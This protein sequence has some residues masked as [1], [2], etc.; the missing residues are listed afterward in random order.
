MLKK[1]K[2]KL[3]KADNRG[4]S[5]VLVIV[6]ATFL[7]ILVSALL[8]GVLLAYKLRFYKLNSLNNF[9]SVEKAMDEIYAG[10]GASTNEHL[11]SAY[12]TTAEI[13]VY[14][15]GG[16][17]ANLTETEANDLFKK[18]FMQSIMEDE[19]FTKMP[20]LVETLQT[21]ITDSNVELVCDNLKIVYTD[22][23]GQEKYVKYEQLPNGKVTSTTSTS[24]GSF[25][26]NNIESITFKNLSVQRTINL[27]PESSGNAYAASGTYVQSI[28][29]DLT[30]RKPE[31]N[32]SFDI[33]GA[34]SD[35]LYNYALLADMGLQVTGTSADTD[36]NIKG[37]VYTASDYYNK[38]YNDDSS[39]KVTNEYNRTVETKWGSTDESAYSGIFVQGER[40]NLSMSSDVVVNSGS[41]A[42]FD[43]AD[44]ILA[45]RTTISSELWTDNIIIGGSEG[46]TI[47][48][49]ANAYVYDD[50][51]L[52]AEKSNLTFTMGSYFGYSYTADDVRSINLLRTAGNLATG[53]KLK[54]HFS[55]S[56][57]IVNGKDS[58]LDFRKLD[59]LY[60]AG[61]SYIEFSKVAASTIT[62]ETERQNM[63]LTDDSD[64]AFTTLNDYSTGQSLD[65]KS[66]QLIF[67]TQWELY[68]DAE[69]TDENGYTHVTLKFPK[70]FSNDVTINNLYQDFIDVLTSNI[71]TV[72]AI[73][74]TVSG[75]D[76]YYLYIEEG[77]N[78]NDGVDDAEEFVEKYYDLLN[79]GVDETVKKLYN[80]VDYDDFQVKL[81]LPTNDSG[82][83]DDTKINASGAV[84]AQ[85][86]DNTL[87]VKASADT[88]LNVENA[89]KSAS[90]SKTFSML[91]G[92]KGTAENNQTFEDL[93]T[94][95]EE[96]AISNT[97]SQEEKVSNF[98]NYMY[99][100]LKDH[101]SVVDK[102]DA[103]DNDIS[104]YELAKYTNSANG[105]TYNA[106]K[107]SNG[108]KLDT[109]DYDYS[110]T[111]L[112]YYVDYDKIF[113]EN[114]AINETE[115]VTN[116]IVI[117]NEND[118]TL[119]STAT[120][121][122]LQGII[123][124][125]GNVTIDSSVKSFRGMIITGAKIIC[126][127][128]V[129]ID[130]S[131]DAS[132][133]ARV[134]EECAKSSNTKLSI[135]TREILK[136]Y[137]KVDESGETEV[138]SSSLS[139]ISYSDILMFQNWKK[140]VE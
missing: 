93:K 94:K 59:A 101:L 87:F 114:L 31:Y 9:Y 111:P 65:V 25:D 135:L 44:I 63:G 30:L 49:A 103:D 41:L 78:D 118:V 64:Y 126:G 99:I 130:I 102:Q 15:K 83:V 73:K 113:T 57:V 7:S 105:Y 23:N 110:L 96:L 34:N 53:F 92:N 61:K 4:S 75:H 54:S 69:T 5:F 2:K 137:E 13:V 37:N 131:A 104:A 119:R 108:D 81:I 33:A 115:P 42:A 14:Y 84:T 27:T 97:A 21:Y 67:L 109:F 22:K 70:T 26:E 74:Q 117:I 40:A 3:K 106:I 107:D 88:T 116:S 60:I 52:N 18:F 120:D 95:S 127:N 19:T 28:T 90:S 20:K 98:I 134:L 43:G 77:D 80:V 76:Y 139:D 16:Q 24:S 62:D 123:I 48:A 133:T 10:I 29:T 86:A 68:D 17:Y 38:D 47:T 140:N 129:D 32:V 91:L 100:N 11:Y 122:S 56:A 50:T 125:G 121:G 39:T 71:Y 112:T 72:E 124:C 58:V 51:E 12:T 35:S 8:M 82:A 36:V 132:F 128:G 6:S 66:N 138:N 46:G 136:N 1:L 89:L 45:G 79:N 55:D 85:N